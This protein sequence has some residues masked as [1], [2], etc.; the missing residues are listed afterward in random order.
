MYRFSRASLSHL[1]TCSPKLI[2]VANEAIKYVDF[3]VIEGYR[4][5]DRQYELYKQGMTQIDGI[6]TK[7]KHNRSPAEAFDLL[8]YPYVVNG[9]NIWKD[10]FRS[11]LFAGR[12]LQIAD[13]MGVKLRWGGER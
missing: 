3:S 10:S 4:S 2:G 9:V 11:T 13:C 7:G 12:V 6:G 8:P 1:H 5:V